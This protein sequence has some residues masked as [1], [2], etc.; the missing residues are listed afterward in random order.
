MS[1]QQQ[2][3]VEAPGTS[4]TVRADTSPLDSVAIETEFPALVDFNKVKHLLSGKPLRRPNRTRPIE[5]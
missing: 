1:E 5:S 4:F 3:T 2:E